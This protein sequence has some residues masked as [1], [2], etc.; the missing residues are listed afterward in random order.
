MTRNS[1][2]RK[3]LDDG[4][5]G[6]SSSSSPSSVS[7]PPQPRRPDAAPDKREDL[8]AALDDDL[9]YNDSFIND[10][11]FCE[12]AYRELQK[13]PDQS[14]QC[15]KRMRDKTTPPAL[16]ITSA[17]AESLDAPCRSGKQPKKLEPSM[18]FRPLRH[19]TRLKNLTE[20]ASR[21]HMRFGARLMWKRNKR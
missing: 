1:S 5:P 6:A 9:D 12:S 19:G 10:I 21:K 8:F 2:E 16:C 4:S 13:D 18:L 20:I 14:I 11:A 15:R 7:L 17:R 3:S